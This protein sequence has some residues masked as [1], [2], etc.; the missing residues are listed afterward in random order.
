MASSIASAASGV[1]ETGLLP[2]E[3]L[4][5]SAPASMARRLAPVIASGLARVP[6]S[7]ITL[8]RRS[9]SQASRTA[10]TIARAVAISPARNAR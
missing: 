1:A 7:R 5:K 6:V 3:V 8:R 4:M 9:P 2:V 10:V